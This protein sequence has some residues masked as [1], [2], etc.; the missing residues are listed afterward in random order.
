MISASDE[1]ITVIYDGYDDE[2]LT[3]TKEQII[4][5]VKNND[6]ILL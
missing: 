2:R 3:W 1:T 6:F 5:D 4:E